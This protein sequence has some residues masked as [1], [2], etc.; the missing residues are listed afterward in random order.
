MF[1]TI[2]VGDD[3][4][5]WY[6]DTSATPNLSDEASDW[7]LDAR[8]NDPIV[9]MAWDNGAVLLDG[10]NPMFEWV[11]VADARSPGVVPFAAMPQAT[12][13]DHLFNAND[14]FWLANADELIEGD[15]SPLHG[16]QDVAQSP[17]T[18]ENARILSEADALT[19]DDVRTAA[20]GN[21]SGTA[22]LLLDDVVG[23]CDDVESVEVP[24][25]GD[26]G[27]PG[28]PAATVELT[29]ACDVLAGWDG[30][31]EL[32]APGAALW[33]ELMGQFEG[34]AFFDE[35]ALFDVPFDPADPVGT[36]RALAAPPAGGDDPILVALGRAVQTLERGDVAVDASMGD[37]QRAPRGDTLVPVHGGLF[38]DGVTNIVGWSPFGTSTEEGPARPEPIVAGT[39]LTDEGYWVNVGTS[40]LMVLGF[41][42]DGPVGTAFLT[43]G[44]TGDPDSP[45][46]ADQSELFSAE[47]WRPVRFADADVAADTEREYVVST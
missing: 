7:W 38:R 29:E 25:R 28:L 39:E 32:D 46:F 36:P 33:R 10:S 3:G 11:E 8:E 45:F 40:F 9:S 23:R 24:A 26:E 27:A 34:E 2:A 42:A 44:N 35:G 47:A 20:L 14:S 12:S 43:Y 13:T 6:A 17:R 31:F 16:E 15:Y 5:A 19:P 1:N 41:T 22:G 18:R 37:V 4:R 30:T 21:T